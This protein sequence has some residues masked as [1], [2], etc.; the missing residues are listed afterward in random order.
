VTPKPER[1]LCFDDIDQAVT[2]ALARA[3]WTSFPSVRMLGYSD[4]PAPTDYVLTVDLALTA[5]SPASSGGPGWAAFAKGSW[6]LQRGGRELAAERVESRSRADFAYGRH[7]GVGAG[8]VVDAIAQHVGGT[9]AALPESS[10]DRP[11]PLPAVSVEPVNSP[12][13]P[14]A[15]ANGRAPVEPTP[16]AGSVVA[17]K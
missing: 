4:K 10:P 1:E 17:T 7:L 6:K 2:Q 13:A 8:E 9:L 12:A 11:I 16:H 15:V 5:A 14:G 3:L